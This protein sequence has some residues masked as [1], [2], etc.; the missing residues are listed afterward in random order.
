MDITPFA[1]YTEV[2]RGMSITL[3]LFI[4]L[5]YWKTFV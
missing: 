3:P 2:I 1:G 4:M 5:L